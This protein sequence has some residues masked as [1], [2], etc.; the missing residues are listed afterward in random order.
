MIPARQAPA[1]SSAYGAPNGA[2]VG[3]RWAEP[4]TSDLTQT[5]SSGYAHL[6]VERD[7]RQLIAA[8]NS[9][10]ASASAPRPWRQSGFR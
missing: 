8:F 9:T 7:P 6:T 1:S 4:V 5:G 3:R 2:V 10:P